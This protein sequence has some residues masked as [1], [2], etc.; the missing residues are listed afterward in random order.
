MILGEIEVMSV[1]LALASVWIVAFIQ[2]CTVIFDQSEFVFDKVS[3][4]DVHD[5]TDAVSV[6]GINEHLQ[7]ITVT[8]T[9]GY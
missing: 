9:A 4:N 2:A 8:V 1:P 6:A 7:L 3:E 5:D